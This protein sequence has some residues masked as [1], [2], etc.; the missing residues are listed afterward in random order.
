MKKLLVS[1]CVVFLCFQGVSIAQNKQNFKTYKLDNGL[2]VILDRDSTQS[3]VAG[4]VAANVGASDEE[5]DATGLAHY[6][7]HMLFK[8][9]QTLGTADWEKEKPLI[10]KIYKLY[11]KLQGAKNQDEIQKINEEIN[12]VS[13]EAS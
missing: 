10:D 5:D 6:L 13:Q 8:G 7:E 2:T 11:D 9:T 4:V 3:Q 12:K 1:F